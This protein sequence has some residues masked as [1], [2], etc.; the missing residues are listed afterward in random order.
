MRF[1]AVVLALAACVTSPLELSTNNPTIRPQLQSAVDEINIAVSG[2]IV[3]M[4]EDGGTLVVDDVADRENL[5]GYFDPANKVISVNSYC[6]FRDNNLVHE[7]GHAL[8]LSHSDDPQS[9]MFSGTSNRTMQQA[10]HS[11]ALALER[12]Q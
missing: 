7:I 1:S 5:C 3:V 6:R 8:G 9:V 10:A 11:L 2:R 12:Q 4:V